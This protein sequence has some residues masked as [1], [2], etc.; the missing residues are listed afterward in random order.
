MRKCW[1]QV[2]GKCDGMSGEHIIS[3]A[4]FKAGCGCPPVIKGVKRIKDGEPTYGAEKANILCQHHNSMLSPLD[5]TVGKLSKFQAQANDENFE[6]NLYLEGELLE[7]WLLKTAINSAAAGWLGPQKLLPSEEIVRAV[8]GL[9]AIPD[10]LGLYS[11]EGICPNHQPRGGASFRPINIKTPEGLIFGG[12]YVS[13]NGMPLFVSFNTELAR[14]LELSDNPEIT[15]YFSESGLKHL[16]HPGALFMD[17][18]R[19]IRLHIGLSWNGVLTFEDG[20][21]APFP[22]ER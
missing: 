1:A 13:V 3:N 11:V 9:E 15:N 19:G 21:T 16:Y 20:S 5:A 18:K 7:R 22:Q 4:L 14:T 8:F 17:R 12:A 10:K 6:E 2:L